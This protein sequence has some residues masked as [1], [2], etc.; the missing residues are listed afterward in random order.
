MYLSSAY[1]VTAR[2]KIRRSP[3]PGTRC[4]RLRQIFRS[5]APHNPKCVT[6]GYVVLQIT[7]V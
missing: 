4:D 1:S 2:F 5:I 7:S 6:L 3:T